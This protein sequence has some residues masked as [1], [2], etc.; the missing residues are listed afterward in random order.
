[1]R[2]LVNASNLKKG[3]GLQVADSFCGL[4]NQ[5]GRH[6]FIVVLSSYQ[7]TTAKRIENYPNVKVVMYDLPK[8]II[9]LLTG[10]NKQMDE[11]VEKEG[12]DAVITVFGPSLWIPRVL[13]VSG[14]A[15]PHCV[16]TDSPYFNRMRWKERVRSYLNRELLIWCFKRCADIYFT[17]NEYISTRLRKILRGKTVYTVTN[18]Y[19]QIFDNPDKWTNEINLS[20][21][22]GITLL[23]I[24]ANYP[25]KNMGILVPTIQYLHKTYPDLRFRFALTLT[26]EEFQ[27]CEDIED[28][29]VFLGKVSIS[30]CPHLYEQ[31]NIVFS[32]TLLECFSAVFPEAMRM[33]RPI[34]TTDLAIT[35]SLCGD[36]ALYYDALSPEAFGDAVYRIANDKDLQVSLIEKGKLQL[37]NY[38]TYEQRATKLINIIEKGFRHR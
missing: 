19:N 20:P 25:H 11:I 18:Y 29:L 22:E 6:E 28:A 13:H 31:C 30:E 1:M 37:K 16:L 24:S 9:T 5:Y 38:D 14:F 3:G 8:T 33:S 10:R 15:R 2:I 21:F 35:R 34:I 4:L 26:K 7:T 17:E 12:V 23:M 27:I 32:T 36:A